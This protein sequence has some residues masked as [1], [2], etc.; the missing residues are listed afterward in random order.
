MK[1]T[2]SESMIDGPSD[3]GRNSALLQEKDDRKTKIQDSGYSFNIKNRG[4]LY[5]EVWSSK[6]SRGADRRRK[7][8]RGEE[9]KILKMSCDMGYL[10]CLT[11]FP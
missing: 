1:K 3:G 10:S 4:G 5:G 9:S 2:S 7:S 11:S 6:V 8:E